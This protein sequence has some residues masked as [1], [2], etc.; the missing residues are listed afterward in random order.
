MDSLSEILRIHTD[1]FHPIVPFDNANDKLIEIDMTASNA[2]L[3]DEII[4]D[5][6]LFSEYVTSFLAK[7]NAKFAIG[8][9][10]EDRIIYKRSMNF[11]A[12]SSDE[13]S[14]SLHLGLDIWGSSGTTVFC[15]V[16]AKVHS[17]ANND[18]YA[19]YGATII[20][21]HELSGCKFHTLYGHLSIRDL[22]IHEGLIIEKGTPFAHFGTPEEN[23]SWPSHLHF[24]IIRKMHGCRGDY[25]GVC[26]N[27]QKEMYFQNCPDPDII[28]QLYRYLYWIR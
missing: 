26:R 28:A 12:I 5:T 25:P 11:D 24:Q 8:G 6:H 19:D 10:G 7:S 22:N 20:L 14:R 17:F 27:S 9:Y 4:M 18:Q 13:E 23:G 2:D 15:P 16:Q 21:E 3:S 1:E